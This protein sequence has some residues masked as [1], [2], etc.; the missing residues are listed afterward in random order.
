M[1]PNAIF[2][3]FSTVIGDWIKFWG[4]P[5]INKSRIRSSQT[6]VMASFILGNAIES[7]LHER[8]Q[9]RQ[10]LDAWVCMKKSSKSFVYWKCTFISFFF[11]F[12]YLLPSRWSTVMT[13]TCSASAIT[14][15]DIWQLTYC[16]GWG[17][18]GFRS[19]G[20]CFQV[21]WWQLWETWWLTE[22]CCSSHQQK[23]LDVFKNPA[24]VP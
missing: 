6:C 14:H 16:L 8:K 13:Y 2:A 5:L 3:F 18:L 19:P 15:S 10:L 17:D 20:V 11:F 23:N 24:A 7:C 1:K 9:R 4:R 21:V 12:I 22:N